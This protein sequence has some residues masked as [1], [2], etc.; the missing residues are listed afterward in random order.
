[1]FKNI[2]NEDDDL[3]FKNIFTFFFLHP[4]TS[5]CSEIYNYIFYCQHLRSGQVNFA[6]SWQILVTTDFKGNSMPPKVTC[7]IR[8]FKK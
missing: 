7:Q 5:L 2:S 4:N 8:F 6:V 3:V 1:M